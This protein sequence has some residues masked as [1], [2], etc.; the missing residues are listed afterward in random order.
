MGARN[1]L[2]AAPSD[3]V[4][5]P[6]GGGRTIFGASVHIRRPRNGSPVAL[7]PVV[8]APHSRDPAALVLLVRRHLQDPSFERPDLGAW[9]A[10][11]GAHTAHHC[12]GSIGR[13]PHLQVNLWRVGIK[14]SGKS[15]RLP[16]VSP[17]GVL[18]VVA[19][20]FA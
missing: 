10:K 15:Y 17:L 19:H 14:G 1:L 11:V 16:L 18:S 5:R 6:F 13:Q 3:Q 2:S 4:S 9:A 7:L 8:V 12:F 20:T